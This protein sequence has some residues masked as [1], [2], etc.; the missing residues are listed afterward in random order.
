M[1]PEC[2]ALTGLCY[3]LGPLNTLSGLTSDRMEKTAAIADAH[4]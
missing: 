3:K 2:C 1:R 4:F